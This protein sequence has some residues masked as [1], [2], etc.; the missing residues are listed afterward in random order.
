MRVDYI[1]EEWRGEALRATK[2]R[3]ELAAG[4][5]CSRAATAPM[6]DC[7]RPSR[8]GAMSRRWLLIAQYAA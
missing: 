6:I 5:C 8:A 2:M 7:P 3:A 4:A 1:A